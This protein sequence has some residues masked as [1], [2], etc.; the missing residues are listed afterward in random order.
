MRRG[1]VSLI[2]SISFLGAQLKE[3][4]LPKNMSRIILRLPRPLLHLP[5]LSQTLRPR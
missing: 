5:R 4:T 3:Y 1:S 2:R